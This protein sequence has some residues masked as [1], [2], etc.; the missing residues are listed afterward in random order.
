MNGD[1]LEDEMLHGYFI[2]ML[3]VRLE[4]PVTLTDTASRFWKP[5]GG[6]GT[7]PVTFDALTMTFCADEELVRSTRYTFT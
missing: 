3:T 5:F 6:T 7:E 4:K 2:V 1:M